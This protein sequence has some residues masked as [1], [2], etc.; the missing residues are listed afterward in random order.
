MHLPVEWCGV[1]CHL[2]PT[3]GDLFRALLF[4]LTQVGVGRT[5]G[6]SKGWGVQGELGGWGVMYGELGMGGL[7]GL[8]GVGVWMGGGMSHVVF[9]K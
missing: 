2:Y 3:D 8:V 7:G 9:R 4:I 6:S 5:G 1:E